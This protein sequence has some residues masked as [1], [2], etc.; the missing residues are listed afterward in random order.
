MQAVLIHNKFVFLILFELRSGNKC[1]SFSPK[2]GAESKT[3]IN[4]YKWNYFHIT[5]VS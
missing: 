5:C 3:S 4:Q 2:A 1:V